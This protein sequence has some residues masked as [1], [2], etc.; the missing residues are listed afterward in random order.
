MTK[1]VL[2]PLG[3]LFLLAAPLPAQTNSAADMAVNRASGPS[4][5]HPAAPKARRRQGRRPRAA[6]WPGPPSFTRT[7]RRSW[8]RLVPALT[9]RP[10]RPFPA[11]SATRLEIARQD[12]RS[13]R[14]AG[15][16]TRHVTRVLKVDP[17]NAAAIAFKKTNDQTIAALKGR[18]PDTPRRNSIPLVVNDKTPAATLVQD[19][20]LLYEMGRFDE[21]EVKL[22]QALKYEPGQPGRVLLF[23]PGQAGPLCARGTKPHKR[24]AKQDG[25]GGEAVDAAGGHRICP[26]RILIS[27][28][29]FYNA[30]ARYRLPHQPQSG[31][32]LQ[33]TE[34]SAHRTI[35]HD[36]RRACH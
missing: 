8:T 29:Q 5:H 22:N 18:M 7:P 25:A 3:F 36:G 27:P 20:K 34:P 6:T 21:A 23:E 26:C 33:Q 15:W 19:G 16:P 13:R 17:H 32:D 35:F 28:L 11:S 30:A 10:P 12:Q 9:P 4:Q 14:F 31:N 1:A 24:S 2:L